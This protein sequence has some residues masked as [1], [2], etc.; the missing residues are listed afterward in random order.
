[1]LGRF[2]GALGQAMK[3]GTSKQA[4]K[5][6]Q[7]TPSKTTAGAAKVK[8]VP[9]HPRWT[10]IA[11]EP[12]P[13]RQQSYKPRPSS[14]KPAHYHD[15]LHQNTHKDSLALKDKPLLRVTLK[16]SLIGVDHKEM[17]TRIAHSLGLRKLHRHVYLRPSV[18]VISRICRI[19]PLVQVARKAAPVD[20]TAKYWAKGFRVIG[21]VSMQNLAS[22]FCN[23]N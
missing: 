23:V 15:L 11:K 4:S 21:T 16:R 5:N 1:M 7:K 6:L 22:P 18:N 17:A 19:F 2:F 20:P 13:Q 8:E 14:W 10:T 3:L 9:K 12:L